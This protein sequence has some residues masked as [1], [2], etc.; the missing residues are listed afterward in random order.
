[1]T[2]ND[3]DKELLKVTLRDGSISVHFGEVNLALITMAVKMAELELD[4]Q[5]IGMQNKEPSVIQTMSPDI[6]KRLR[7]K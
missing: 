3:K 1:M 4:N 5:I 7:G 6:L 2:D